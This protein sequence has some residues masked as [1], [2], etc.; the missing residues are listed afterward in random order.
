MKTMDYKKLL[1]ILLPKFE[2]RYSDKCITYLLEYHKVDKR[3]KWIDVWLT[4]ERV[5]DDTK[6]TVEK[7]VLLHNIYSEIINLSKYA[8]PL[9]KG[10][11]LNI[12]ESQQFYE[13]GCTFI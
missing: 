8:P 12:G 2:Y 9:S 6:V 7:K 11:C 1:E 13:E 5:P 10:V 4:I 3:D